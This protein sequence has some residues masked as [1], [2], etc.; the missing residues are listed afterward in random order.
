MRNRKKNE[1]CWYDEK[2]DLFQV[3]FCSYE[4]SYFLLILAFNLI[5]A[6]Y[7][8]KH[9]SVFPFYKNRSNIIYKPYN[10]F[11]S[12]RRSLLVI[13][14]NQAHMASY[15]P[16]LPCGAVAPL[17]VVSKRVATRHKNGFTR[18]WILASLK[19]LCKWA[20][21]LSSALKGCP[22]S[23]LSIGK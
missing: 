1:I 21:M 14:F 16:P 13:H 8:T 17:E 18:F 5:A 12:R 3:F 6:K 11:C 4:S 22:R 19:H 23:P 15:E 20:D 9:A 2:K 7:N 10:T